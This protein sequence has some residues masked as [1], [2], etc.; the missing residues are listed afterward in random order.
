MKKII[1]SVLIFICLSHPAQVIKNT[2]ISS[3]LLHI[4]PFYVQIIDDE[5]KKRDVAKIEDKDQQVQSLLDLLHTNT[6][7]L[8]ELLESKNNTIT[9]VQS[10]MNEKAR[11]RQRM[12]EEQIQTFNEFI[13]NVEAESSKIQTALEQINELKD[14][15]E[16]QQQIMKE[17][18]DYDKILEKLNEI[19]EHQSVAIDKLEQIV[20]LGN[21]TAAVLA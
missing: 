7:R 8:S 10:K 16:V 20:Q 6:R 19:T 4:R 13:R 5:L 2:D 14:M 3:E 15:K 9:M 1:G 17:D 12:T 18:M 21:Y 11:A